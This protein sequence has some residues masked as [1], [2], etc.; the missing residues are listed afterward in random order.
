MNTFYKLAVATR[1]F[2]TSSIR[3]QLVF[4]IT[5]VHAVLMTLFVIDLVERQRTFMHEQAIGQTLSLAETLAANSTSWVLANDVIGLE[6]VVHS[7]SKY[8]GVVY[9]MVLSQDGRVLGH[10]DSAKTGFYVSD[11]VSLTMLDKTL[12]NHL[13]VNNAQLIDVAVPVLAN[14]QLIGWARVGLSQGAT[15][16]GL[17]I[18]T[19]DGIMYTVLAIFVGT[20]FAIFMARGLTRGLRQ[21]VEVSDRVRQGDTGLRAGLNREDELGRL[22]VNFDLM[23]DALA[24]TQHNLVESEERFD[25]AMRGSNDGLWDWN[26]RTN[27]VY[28]SPRWKQMLGYE[29]HEIDNA[30]EEWSQRLLPEDLARAE[31]YI[32]RH[33]SGETALYEC[34]Y[35]V[36][37]KD[38]Q[39]RWH[40]E[41]GIA[42]RDADGKAYRMVGTTT[43]ISE[44]KL[45][46]SALSEEK[47]RAMVTLSS[48]GD[49]VI[50][51]TVNGL[52]EF[53][54]PV[55]EALTGWKTEEAKGKPLDEVF[56]I[57]DEQTDLVSESPVS[58]CLRQGKP[59]KPANH[60][61]LINRH[62]DGVAIEDSAAPIRDSEGNIIGV[63]M[64]FHDVSATREMARQMSWQATHDSLTGLF[65]RNEFERRLRRLLE[66]AKNDDAQHAFL[67]LDL[68]QFKIVNDTCGHVAGDEL[69]KQLSFLLHEQVRKNDTLARLGGDEFGMLLA[70]C[71]LDKAI[72][73][74][75]KL[76]LTVK[77]FRFVWQDKTFEIGVSVGMVSVDSTSESVVNLLSAADVA[78]YAAKDHGRNRIHVYQPDDAELAQRHGEMQWVS[79]I[80]QAL[81][82]DRLVLYSQTIL[83]IREK[84]SVGHFEV[85]VRMRDENGRLIPPNS[86]IPAAERYNLM[87]AIDTWVIRKTFLATADCLK[88]AGAGSI[89]MV[90]INL[91][92]NTFNDDNFLGFIR[93]QLDVHQLPGRLFCF[94]IT[95]TSAIANLPKAI[96]FIRELKADGCRFALDDFGSGLSSY[97][98]LKNLP[99]DYLKIDGSFVRN[100]ANDPIDRAMVNA[101]N[102]VGHVMGI[103]TI[104]EFVEDDQILG[105]LKGIG[106]DYAQGYGI[107]PPVPLDERLGSRSGPVR[108]D[109]AAAS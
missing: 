83:P 99:V 44:T 26:I 85:L 105:V 48:I 3:R 69:L 79:R 108:L 98:Y 80:T 15:S 57:I 55:A 33:L 71:G 49:A 87:P 24:E 76:R 66:S 11:E 47:E 22:A 32:Q 35:R 13:L 89:D 78:C 73:I 65:N 104:A 5:L 41:R 18:A 52:V 27:E 91:S 4:G 64:V 21:L 62:G 67:Y 30:L 58:R 56:H 84:P 95:E 25:L 90:G 31:A 8:P 38:G 29:E 101:I 1:R 60:T 50:T 107:A 68:D 54:N 19:R 70:D 53:M 102:Q 39:Y 51:T 106:V 103:K 72:A 12:E 46:E 61:L 94:E 10:T 88:G 97:A 82:E 63:V 75:E 14:R 74:A 36:R 43:D 17:R 59:I 16:A 96:H 34:T 42:I 109:S 2:W 100:M 93:E 6:E 20:L 45:T 37:H 77:D 81:E 28:Y 9:A 7:Q 92:G 40:L 23:L 86:F